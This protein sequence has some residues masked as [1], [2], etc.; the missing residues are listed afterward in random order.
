MTIADSSQ[1]RSAFREAQISKSYRRKDRSRAK[2]LFE[3]YQ[4]YTAQDWVWDVDAEQTLFGAVKTI[5][6]TFPFGNCL[7]NIGQSTASPCIL[8]SKENEL[9][10][11]YKNQLTQAKAVYEGPGDVKDNTSDS[12]VEYIKIRGRRQKIGLQCRQGSIL[13]VSQRNA[14][15][16]IFQEQLKAC[17]WNTENLTEGTFVQL[18]DRVSFLRIKEIF[19]ELRTGEVFLQGI[20]FRSVT[21][22]GILPQK[23]ASEVCMIL[24]I[25][26]DDPRPEETQA[27]ETICVRHVY[28]IRKLRLTNVNCL[29]EQEEQMRAEA[30]DRQ[31]TV[32]CRLRMT[33]S[34]L[35]VASRQKK[36]K[37]E[38]TIR[39]LRRDECDRNEGLTNQQLRWTWRGET[40]RR[41]AQLG[42]LQGEK[43]FLDQETKASRMQFEAHPSFSKVDPDHQPRGAVGDILCQTAPNASH[44]YQI[45][46]MG[47]PGARCI[48]VDITTGEVVPRTVVDPLESDIAWL[49]DWKDEDNNTD[50]EVEE[51]PP[52]IQ[53]PSRLADAVLAEPDIIEIDPDPILRTGSS[54]LA[55]NMAG[56]HVIDISDD[57]SMRNE[58]VEIV[59]SR[60]LKTHA[61]QNVE[62]FDQPT[63]SGSRY[64]M[65]DCFCGTGGMSR[66]AILAG[67]RI[68]SAF[69]K[70][71][72]ACK[73][74]SRNFF[75]VKVYCSEADELCHP[76]YRADVKA[77][78]CHI[79]PPCQPFSPAHTVEGK[80][81]ATNRAALRTVGSLL[82]VI[83]P[84]VVVLEETDGLQKRHVEWFDDCMHEFIERGFSLRYKTLVCANYGVPQLRRRLFVIA[85][86]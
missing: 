17:E 19:K 4:L 3:L 10:D 36:N 76:G 38:Q 33:T 50:S 69:D 25:D 74:Y 78:I 41:G 68:S 37:Y 64:T 65:V 61:Q 21:A 72:N 44:F 7:F 27:M 67:L 31:E 23:F 60:V 58:D 2:T 51:V 71:T 43:D 86:W 18:N 9:N 42:W 83:K 80:N 16:N 5:F 52:P 49:D 32:V 39:Y 26:H 14:P 46:G 77:D 48:K 66:G 73:S 55:L 22:Y 63:S 79:S 81:D 35:N 1:T 53:N 6:P 13:A 70:D 47:A 82:D 20:L 34:Y 45:S 15:L 84:R 24:E 57:E 12:D 56:R 40:C 59:G 29:H 11:A 62:I 75:K 85:S 30:Y 54:S 8:P 28:R